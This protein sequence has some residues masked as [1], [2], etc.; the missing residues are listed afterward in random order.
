MSGT[1]T[2]KMKSV[3]VPAP[4]DGMNLIANPVLGFELT[5]ARILTNYLVYDWGIRQRGKETQVF[6]SPAVVALYPFYDQGGTERMIAVGTDN[7]IYRLNAYND[8]TPDNITGSVTV[9]DVSNV[10][11]TS[12]NKHIFF[13][14]ETDTPWLYSIAGAS[15]C[16]ATSI[17]GPTGTE[18]CFGWNYKNRLYLLEGAS[19]NATSVW[20][21]GVGAISGSFTENDFAQVLARSSYIL[22]GFS[23]SFNQGNDA[24]E[25]F[26]LISIEGEVLVYAGDYPGATNWA[27]TIRA[28]I[29]RPTGRDCIV[30]LGQE[31]LVSTARGVIALS[32][33]FSAQTSG[34]QYYSITRKLGD[35]A[36]FRDRQFV[37]DRNSPFLYGSDYAAN[38]GAGDPET[39][40]VYVQNYERGAW[41]YI[42]L[43]G[44]AP[45][46]L[47]CFDGYFFYGSDQSGLYRIEKDGDGEP[48]GR[49]PF[50]WAT[51]FFN[52]GT[53]LQKTP[54]SL[55]LIGKD[56][57]DAAFR[58]AHTVATYSEFGSRQT[59]GAA[60]TADSSAVATGVQSGQIYTQELIPSGYGHQQSYVISTLQ[61][62]NREE[63]YGFELFY[64]EG[65]VY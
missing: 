35:T 44:D 29:P 61:E 17:T 57:S 15:N 43:Y 14:N 16:G 8:T 27:L 32:S 63:L 13:F 42:T 38:A 52:F 56:L 40:K 20:Y 64:E 3:Y 21:G 24:Q 28:T 11:I 48:D 49:V 22:T 50:Q 6:N 41:S 60:S 34:E 30:R 25:Y 4:V 1:P 26:V 7:E 55:R 9:T 33:V 10:F 62:G 46:A 36:L 19:G 39:W 18:I 37:I 58:F 23:W 54:R 45:S 31:V 5:E 65:G 47:A 12:F 2:T 59:G 51:P 53:N